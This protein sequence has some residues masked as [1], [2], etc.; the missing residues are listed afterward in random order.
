VSFETY[1]AVVLYN[2]HISSYGNDCAAHD[3]RGK[4][5]KVA[6]RFAWAA[7][8]AR[9]LKENRGSGRWPR[10]EVAFFNLTGGHRHA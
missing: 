5:A 10:A 1:L 7:V 9:Q 4:S 6:V 3:R 2:L 8:R